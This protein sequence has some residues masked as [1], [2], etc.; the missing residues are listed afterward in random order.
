[1]CRSSPPERLFEGWRQKK[2]GLAARAQPRAAVAR[3]FAPLSKHP[4]AAPGSYTMA[5][6]EE[7]FLD[8]IY[9]WLRI[10]Y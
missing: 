4:G 6:I 10:R 7:K 8:G 5:D 3:H 9:L 1:M 2:M